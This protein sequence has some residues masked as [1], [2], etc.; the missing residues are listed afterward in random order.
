MVTC[1]LFVHRYDISV[2]DTSTLFERRFMGRMETG[3][4]TTSDPA[5]GVAATTWKQHPDLPEYVRNIKPWVDKELCVQARDDKNRR[6]ILKVYSKDQ[7]IVPG[8][9]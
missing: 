9:E 5:M 6:S 3:R 8:V 1:V 7:C 2:I 4:T